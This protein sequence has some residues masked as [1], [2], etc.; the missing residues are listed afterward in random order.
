MPL[1]TDAAGNLLLSAPYVGVTV[2]R[3][4]GTEEPFVPGSIGAHG[5]QRPTPRGSPSCSTPT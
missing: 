5:P 1:A 3:P 4:D 2:R